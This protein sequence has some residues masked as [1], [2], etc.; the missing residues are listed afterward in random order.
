MVTS[1]FENKPPTVHIGAKIKN[2][3]PVFVYLNVGEYEPGE[4]DVSYRFQATGERYMLT[5]L[6]IQELLLQMPKEFL[7]MAS[8]AEIQ[9]MMRAFGCNDDLQAW[10]DMRIAQINAHDSS[11]EV[12]HFTIKGITGWLDKNTRVA[13]VNMYQLHQ[14]L[15]GV[16]LPALWVDGN[17]IE[18]ESVEDA[19]KALAKIEVYASQCYAA[20]QELLCIIKQFMEARQLLEI[21]TFE[22][23]SHYPPAITL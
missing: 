15:E 9:A 22:Y 12:N 7:S 3:I 10:G 20:T 16:S 17:K 11:N 8:E 2:K 14:K 1:L 13:L 18:F 21:Q 19:L 5:E 6:T 23:R 4:S